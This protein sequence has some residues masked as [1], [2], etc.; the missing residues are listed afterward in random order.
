VRIAIATDDGS[1]IAAHTGRCAAFAIFEIAEGLARRLEDR[2]NTFTGHARGECHHDVPT[3]HDDSAHRAENHTH[4]AHDDLLE[5]IADCRAL[6]T[7]G[8]GPRLV[9]DLAARGIDA[10]VCPIRDLDQAA[11]YYAQGIL[12]KVTDGGTCPK[13]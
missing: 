8:L 4:H 10:H 3:G 5:A 9:T 1:T 11:Q 6:V 13:H 2:P 7:R 12:P